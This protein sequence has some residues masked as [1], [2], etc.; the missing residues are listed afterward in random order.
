IRLPLSFRTGGSFSAAGVH[1]SQIRSAIFADQVIQAL[2]AA[3]GSGIERPDIAHALL[4]P[5]VPTISTAGEVDPSGGPYG[6]S[7]SM[8]KELLRSFGPEE[9]ISVVFPAKGKRI[10]RIVR[11]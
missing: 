1:P 7:L 4:T 5:N 11:R 2:N 10:P 8:W 3:K 9:G 6:F